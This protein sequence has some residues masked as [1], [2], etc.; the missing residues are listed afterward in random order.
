LVR[1]LEL[2]IAVRNAQASNSQESDG[3]P[4][5]LA[6]RINNKDETGNSHRTEMSGTCMLYRQ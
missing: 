4:I 3:T 1:E 2:V 5:V 6:A